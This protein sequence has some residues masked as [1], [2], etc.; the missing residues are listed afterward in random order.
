LCHGESGVER[1]GLFQ[2][3]EQQFFFFAV[4]TTIGEQTEAASSVGGRLHR[5]G[6]LD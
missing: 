2:R 3:G 4:M 5:T 1:Q 6:I